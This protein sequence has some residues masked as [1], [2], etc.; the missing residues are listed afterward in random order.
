VTIVL[1]DDAHARSFEPYASTRPVSEMVAGY[2][3][4]RDRW[5]VALQD[6]NAQFLA[7]ERMRNFDEGPGTRPASGVIPAGTI[8]AGA[9]TPAPVQP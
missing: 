1:Y 4:I 3:L 5:K 8:V 7:G 6:G 2:G 9:A